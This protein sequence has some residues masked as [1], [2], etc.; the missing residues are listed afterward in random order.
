MNLT[1]SQP[2]KLE[3][4]L[5]LR[6]GGVMNYPLLAG[7]PKHY[8]RALLTRLAFSKRHNFFYA[9]IPK[10]ANSTVVATLASHIEPERLANTSAELKFRL[11]RAPTM[12]QFN[13]AFKFSIVRDPTDRVL[14]SYLHQRGKMGI[15]TNQPS[16]KEFLEFLNAISERDFKGNG[17]FLP[18]TI[19]IAGGAHRMDYIGRVETLEADLK[20]ICETVFGTFNFVQQARSHRTDA[21]NKRNQFLTPAAVEKIKFLY[22]DDFEQLGYD[23]PLALID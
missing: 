2:R 18:Q 16:K 4:A 22:K 13:R 11:N 3:A 15:R 14:S 6:Y 21:S 17:H 23:Q 20:H 5:I 8:S 19:M 9:R 10:A 12:R 1:L 7:V